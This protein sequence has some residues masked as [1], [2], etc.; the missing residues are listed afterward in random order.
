MAQPRTDGVDVH[1]GAQQVRCG[2][3]AAMSLGT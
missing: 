3:V 1:S 2:R